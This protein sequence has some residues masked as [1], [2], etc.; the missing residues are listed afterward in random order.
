MS[1]S[2]LKSRET[3]VLR[4][5]IFQHGARRGVR[6]VGVTR[7]QAFEQAALALTGMVTAISKVR[8]ECKLHIFCEATSNTLLFLEWLDAV[9]HMMA[10]YRILFSRFSVAIDGYRL[11]ATAW[12]EPI[13]REDQGLVVLPKA[14]TCADLIVIQNSDGTWLAQCAIDA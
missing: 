3:T 14:V 4:S 1:E 7:E 13:E 2:H 10:T 12:G 5:E 6:G 11:R 9:I 8:P